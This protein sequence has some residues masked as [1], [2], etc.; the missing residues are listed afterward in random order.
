MQC[1]QYN[2][3]NEER[4]QQRPI[5]FD[6]KQT[7]QSD[8]HRASVL[9]ASKQNPSRAQHNT[10]LQF[11]R[12]LRRSGFDS[13]N[14]CCDLRCRSFSSVV[15]AVLGAGV[16]YLQTHSLGRPTVAHPAIPLE[17]CELIIRRVSFFYLLET[18]IDHEKRTTNK[19]PY[20]GH[21]ICHTTSPALPKCNDESLSLE[22]LQPIIGPGDQK[23]RKKKRK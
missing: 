21:S 7:P 20:S 11:Q 22:C 5:L 6:G 14:L 23:K 18:F 10:V 1:G 8:C 15:L 2:T 12:N 13:S 19:N 16:Y 17:R 3:M 9:L 4:E